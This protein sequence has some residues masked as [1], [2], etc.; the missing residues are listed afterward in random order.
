MEAQRKY[1]DVPEVTLTTSYCPP[2]ILFHLG[3]WRNWE[4]WIDL[5]KTPSP[6][7]IEHLFL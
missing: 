3:T 7:F 5:L 4:N 6:G 1:Q 2:G